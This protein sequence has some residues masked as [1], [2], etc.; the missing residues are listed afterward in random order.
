MQYETKSAIGSCATLH[1]SPSRGA[2][3]H[4]LA[5]MFRLGQGQGEL[6]AHSERPWASATFAGARHAISL[7]F[8]GAES[9]AAGERL[10]DLLP[11]HEF[12]IPGHLVA[13][14]TVRA[15][16]HRLLPDEKLEL[17]IE[18]LLLEDL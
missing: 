7:S 10:L 17:E 14:A 15:A 2:W 16:H 6:A 3:T 4:L 8:A 1:R 5:Q 18:I 11:D 13:D 12:D 9:V